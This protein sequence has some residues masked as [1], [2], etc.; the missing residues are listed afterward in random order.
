MSIIPTDPWNC[1]VAKKSRLGMIKSVE[2][3]PRNIAETTKHLI[4][5]AD[6]FLTLIENGVKNE[7]LPEFKEHDLCL[8]VKPPN[9]G[10]SWKVDE[11]TED[12]KPT[13]TIQSGTG[14]SIK[15]TGNTYN[16]QYSMY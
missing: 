3:N 11:G 14:S 2:V 12:T 16:I 6:I 13:I 8:V 7:D 1:E 9:V 10:S 4:E 15:K 5:F